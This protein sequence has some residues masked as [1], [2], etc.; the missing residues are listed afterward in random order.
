MWRLTNRTLDARECAT[1][2]V[3]RSPCLGGNTSDDEVGSGYCTP[4]HEGPLCAV[5][6]GRDHY[7]NEDTMTCIHCVSSLY[8]LEPV[9]SYFVPLLAIV[10]VLGVSKVLIQ[11]RPSGLTF[12]WRRLL[13]FKVLA[14][15][16]SFFTRVKLLVG[17]YQIVGALPTVYGVRVPEELEVYV[18]WLS[19]L[20]REQHSN[21]GV[22]VSLHR[23][24][25]ARA[26]K[27]QSRSLSSSWMRPTIDALPAVG[28]RRGSPGA[29]RHICRSLHCCSRHH[30]APAWRES[31]QG[32][33]FK[34]AAFK[35]RTRVHPRETLDDDNH[36]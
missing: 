12:V 9:L 18:G 27:D 24:A 31:I 13:W 15:H 1:G 35:T 36:E 6:T 10:V 4:G 7:Y 25:T 26:G 22:H 33:E 8:W 20:V 16:A 23:C 2:D 3:S 34:T 19:W 32:Q 5:C 11:W 29:D 28:D 14:A 17:F 21:S 30:K